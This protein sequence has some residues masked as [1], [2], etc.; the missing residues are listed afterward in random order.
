MRKKF[1][2]RALKHRIRQSKGQI[3][4][5]QRYLFNTATLMHIERWSALLNSRQNTGKGDS[6]ANLPA[7]IGPL[8][9]KQQL[10]DARI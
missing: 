7:L 2:F 10:T 1:D 6:W 5:N 9:A 3:V 8:A 4:K